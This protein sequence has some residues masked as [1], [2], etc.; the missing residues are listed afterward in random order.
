MIGL[1][2]T[3]D[4]IPIAHHVFAGNTA[5]VT[6]L[7]AVLDDLQARFGVG[8]ICVVADRGLISADNVETVEGVR[9]RPRH[10]HPA[11]PGPHLCRRARGRRPGPTPPGSPS[12]R[13]A[14]AACDVTLADGR[15][16]VVVAS[17]ERWQRDT[18]RTAELV[19]RTE[20][21]LLALERR[22]R[23][24]D[25][26]DP[27][28]IGRAAQR[29][30]GTSA[31]GP[32]LRRRDRPRPVPLPLRRSRLRLRRPPRRPLRARHLP[33][34]PPGHHRPGRRWPTGNSSR[35]NA[36]S[37]SSRTSC[38]SG[39]SA[40]GPNHASAPTSPSASTPASSKPSSPA[41]SAAPTCATPTSPTNTSASERALR[42]LGRVRALTLTAGDRTI[43]LVTRRTPLQARILTAL[44]VDTTGWDRPHIA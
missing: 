27:A 3:G 7:P 14:P 42:E 39:P 2:C 40:T 15:R 25:L 20:A 28:K 32:A 31:G 1:L 38:T 5:D 37:G 44:G 35:S 43:N 30:L 29:I 16:A 18:L 34:H 10:R 36:G 8:R 11:A 4:G 21:K 41:P 22:V 17:F 26:T 13:P 19:A 12:P 33:H 24:G 23:D 6:T 9:V